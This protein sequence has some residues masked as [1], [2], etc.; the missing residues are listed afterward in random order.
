M[1]IGI[2][3]LWIFGAMMIAISG[4]VGAAD[5]VEFTNG[6]RDL[7]YV[8]TV[9]GDGSCPTKPSPIRDQF[10]LSPGQKEFVDAKGAQKEVCYVA[11]TNPD[12]NQFPMF[13]G[14][15]VGPSIVDVARGGSCRG[16]KEIEGSSYLV[17]PAAASASVAGSVEFQVGGAWNDPLTQPQTATRCIREAWG[18]WPWC[19]DWRT[20]VEWAT[21][22]RFLRNQL[23]LVVTAPDPPTNPA[24]LKSK[25]EACLQEA[26]IAAA[27][28]GVVAAYAS[29]GSAA[30]AAAERAFTA[31]FINC[32]TGVPEVGVRFDVRSHWT[33][34]GTCG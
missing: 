26:T 10:S 11:S 19:E 16:V 20:C 33:P 31:V 21:D 6:G 2:Q 15:A 7:L 9:T 30:I 34:W 17:G 3:S 13:C 8:R 22:C 25:S 23:F 18:H 4:S 1:K 32:M 24:D 14:V 12:V 27:V 29:G 5:S 28:A